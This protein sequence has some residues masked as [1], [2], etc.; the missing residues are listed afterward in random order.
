MA[1]GRSSEPE[2]FSG[3]ELTARSDLYSLGLVLYELFTGRRAFTAP[4]IAELV[5]QLSEKIDIHVLALPAGA[6]VARPGGASRA[7]PGSAS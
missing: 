1:A 3:V 5:R 6:A 4:T 2:Q 7:R